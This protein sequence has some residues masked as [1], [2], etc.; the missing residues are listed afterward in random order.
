MLPM[1]FEALRSQSIPLINRLF[2]FLHL[3]ARSLILHRFSGDLWDFS[4]LLN[5]YSFFLSVPFSCTYSLLIPVHTLFSFLF[6]LFLSLCTLLTCCLRLCYSCTYSI[7]DS[8]SDAPGPHSYT[9]R[10]T[11]LPFCF[12]R[13]AIPCLRRRS[14]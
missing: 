11:V 13:I 12:T 10:D 4:A 9:Y 1:S 3:Q 6:I 8:K 2:V 14:R 5:A 7:F